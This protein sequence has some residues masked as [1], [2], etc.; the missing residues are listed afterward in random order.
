MASAASQSRCRITH[1]FQLVSCHLAALYLRICV[2]TYLYLQLKSRIYISTHVLCLFTHRYCLACFCFAF[3]VSL[4]VCRFIDAV[5]IY[6]LHLSGSLCDC[7]LTHTQAGIYTCV[8]EDISV[9][10]HSLF[11]LLDSTVYSNGACYQVQHAVAARTRQIQDLCT[12]SIEIY[13]PMIHRE[14]CITGYSSSLFFSYVFYS[15]SGLS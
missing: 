14:S 9:Y 2:S 7:P 10:L 3:Y 11:A 4:S 5:Y 13:S 6:N 1:R 8:F 15:P 12:T